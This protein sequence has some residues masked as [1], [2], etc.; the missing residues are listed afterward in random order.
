MRLLFFIL[1]LPTMLCY[2]DIDVDDDVVISLKGRTFLGTR[3]VIDSFTIRA[4]DLLKQSQ[5]A[6][7]GILTCHLPVRQGEHN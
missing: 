7:E 3:I 1:E 2:S 4:E 6:P 5:T